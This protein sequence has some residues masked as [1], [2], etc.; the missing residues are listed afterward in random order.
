MGTTGAQ[1]LVESLL[2]EGVEVMFGIPGGVLIPFFDKL[3]EGP[4]KVMLTRHEQGAGHMADGYARASGKVGVCIATSGPGATNLVTALATAYIDN[5]PVIALTGQVKTNL[6]GSD[7]FQEADITGITRPVTKHNYLV[8]DVTELAR[9]V[10]EAFHIASTGSPG[11]VLIDLPVDVTTAEL[12]GQVDREMRLPGYKP[13]VKG[14]PGQVKRAADAIN[15][16][17]RPVIY[18]GGGVIISGAADEL[19]QLARKAN[20][21]VATTLL[22]LGCFPEDDPLSLHMLGMHG[23]VYANY[24]VTNS[25]LIVAVGA[26]FDDRV[27]GKLDAFAPQASIVHVDVAPASIGKNVPVDVPVV[28]DAAHVLVELL[29]FVEHRPREAWIKQ[30]AEWKE[31][32][33][34]EYDREAPSVKPQFVVE[35]IHRVTDG[36]AII[37]TDVGQHQMWAAQYYTYTQPR[38]LLSSGGLGTMGYGLPAG[39]GAQVARPDKAVFV[40]AGDGSLQ[41][42]IQELS[43]AVGNRLPIKIAL[44]NNGY[45][46]MVRQW[47]ELF[48][49]RRYSSTV[50]EPEN[51]DFV[52]VAEAYGAVGIR[53]DDKA[54]VGKAL[55]QAMEVTDRPVLIDFR[56]DRE[57]N[58]FPMVP[59]GEAI[60]RMISGMA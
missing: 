49:D 10:R 46:G 56:I 48:F 31:R 44:L 26:R 17:E 43:T 57:E 52:G 35:E 37:V 59:A 47:Q 27:T 55:E 3:Y 12:N 14:H 58:V 18:A 30:I 42:N 34:L 28:G 16:S 15:N 8:K 20:A 40:I 32:H 38:S 33:P 60:D 25:D 21:P 54:A 2:E 7:A 41:M 53:V 6:I 1:I 39:I 23:T 9:T 11:P 36:K 13:S 29:K 24:A 45:L 4:L 22:G 19:A 5:V 50:L 51:P